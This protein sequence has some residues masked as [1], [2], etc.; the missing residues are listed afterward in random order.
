MT[1]TPAF[2]SSPRACAV[3][4]AALALAATPL[5]ARQVDPTTDTE[6]PLT[7]HHAV[8]LALAT[9]PALAAARA[10][11]IAA[12]A[13]HRE[14]T[15]A[16][17]PAAQLGA[18]T[19]QYEER[20]LVAPIHGFTP[21]LFPQ[22]DRT[23]IQGELRVSWEIYSGG[24]RTGRI[25]QS[26]AQ[27]GAATARAQT[28]HQLAIVRTVFIYLDALTLREQL[29]AHGERLTAL[30]A[31]HRRVDTL[32]AAGRAA[33]VDL[34]RIEAGVAGA[35]AERVRLA[36]QLDAVERELARLTGLPAD[37]TRASSL[38]APALREELPA[39]AV[40]AERDALGARAIAA[41]P[42][43]AQA[44]QELR[45]AE[46]A[47]A[48]A[49]SARRPRATAGGAL[50]EYGST[51]GDFTGEWN[52]AIRLAFPLYEGGARVERIAAARANR[53]AAAERLRAAR[54][55]AARDVDRA[56]AS[57]EQSLASTSSLTRAVDS[58]GE[59]ARIEQL[60]LE[61]GTGTQTDFLDAQAD[62][63]AARAD[64]SRARHGAIAAR[65]ELARAAGE[66]STEW[67]D[68]E[69][70]AAP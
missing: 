6:P 31:E 2:P 60:R 62:L 40:T 13:T 37:A 22:F 14:S 7:L 1:V 54:E 28:E 59:V 53:D 48:V 66:L 63:L 26:A 9:A 58:F 29:A 38:R 8:E 18:S 69:L 17:R 35:E 36:A 41:Q 61:A 39:D 25:E 64:L 27:A 45:A 5:R 32:L 47:V 42:A 21:D 65:V 20:S 46:A 19:T 11:E 57:L 70:E 15:S 34:R 68:L 4:A 51:A 16:R 55:Q 24:A 43:V 12:S 67:L 3:L 50:V 30:A 33:V 49:E 56:L 23:L 10:Q 52:A 44:D